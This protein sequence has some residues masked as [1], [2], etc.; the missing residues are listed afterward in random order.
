[1]A[2][3][4]LTQDRRSAITALESL[5]AV[6]VR[7]AIDDFGAAASPLAKLRELPIDTLKL[8]SSFV[9]DLGDSPR[10]ASLLAALLELG[11]ALGLEVVAKGVETEAQLAQLRELGCD[12]AQGYALGHPVTEDQVYDMLLAEVA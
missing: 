4:E 8:H 9:G 12:A 11:H 1:V 3:R 10:A 5:K 6:G 2:E 7:L